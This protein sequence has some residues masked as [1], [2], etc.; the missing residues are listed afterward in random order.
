MAVLILLYPHA[1]FPKTGSSQGI[2][3]NFHNTFSFTQGQFRVYQ[4]GN[5]DVEQKKQNYQ[6]INNSA[7]NLCFSKQTSDENIENHLLERCCLDE[8]P[9]S[10]K[11]H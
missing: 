1:D 5:M 3:H 4:H 2:V 9:Y 6:V 10:Q 7:Q 8:P 11:N